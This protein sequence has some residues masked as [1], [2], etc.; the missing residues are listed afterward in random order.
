MGYSKSLG[1][2]RETQSKNR[3]QSCGI[4]EYSKICNERLTDYRGYS[5]CGWC[6]AR[7]QELEIKLGREVEFE[8]FKNG[9]QIKSPQKV[10]N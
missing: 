3:C 8:R 7:W 10:K 2:W 5:I 6:I 9:E 1:E 4:M